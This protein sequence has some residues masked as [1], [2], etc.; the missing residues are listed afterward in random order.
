MSRNILVLGAFYLAFLLVI[1]R[2]FYWQV[3]R[4]SELS[5]AAAQQ[6]YFQLQIEPRRGEVVSSDG[7]PL[8]THKTAYLAYAEPKKITDKTAFIKKIS[9]ILEA[10]EASISSKFLDDSLYWVPI[11]HKVPEEKTTKLKEANLDGLGFEKESLRYYPEASL[12]AHLLGFVGS[13]ENGQDRGYFGLEGYYEQALRGKPGMLI[14]EKDAYG[15]PILLGGGKRV[16]AED[17]QKLELFLDRSVQF[18]L[19]SELK[20]GI[21]RYGAKEGLIAVMDPETGGILGVAANPAYDP[22]KFYEYPTDIYPHPLVAK[23]YEPGS[24]F[25]ILIMA[26]G[27]NQRVI[28]PQTIFHEEGPVHIGEYFVKTWNDKYNGDLTMT[29]VLEKSSN[30]GMVFVGRKLGREKVS[31]YLKNFGLGELSGIDVQEEM[32]PDLRDSSQWAEIDLATISFGQGIAVTPLQMLRAVGAIAN[33][34]NLMQPRVVRRIID[35]SGKIIE[36]KPKITNSVIKPSTAKAVTEMMISAVDQGD[37][38]W[39]KPAGYRIA[40]KTG[41]AQIPIEGHYDAEKT[42]ASFVGFAPADNP[43]FVMLVILT[44]P[45]TSPWGSETAAPLFFKIARELFAY[46]GIS[47]HD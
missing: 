40:G 44:E 4:G 33:E 3:V 21:E 43:R 5:E 8:V 28:G 19:E 12:A 9:E 32:S 15:L 41:T 17:G 25:K 38:K 31:E 6:Y 37:A 46:Y 10:D 16:P 20:A 30:P 29:Q 27:I 24:T 36:Q 18:I 47:P 45:T 1:S 11:A 26:A 35:G 23:T 22:K 34:G 2:L 13:D 42:I 14:Q 39:A 7:S